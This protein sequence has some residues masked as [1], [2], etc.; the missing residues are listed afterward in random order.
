MVQEHMESDYGSCIQ[1]HDGGEIHPL[2]L[3]CDMGEVRHPDVVFV[4]RMIGKEEV[5]INVA[6]CSWFQPFL[7][8]PAIG[9]E[10][11]EMPSLEAHASC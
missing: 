1:I 8:S 2:A 6:L 9:L 3:K 7:A 5:G 10:S 4:L 11:K